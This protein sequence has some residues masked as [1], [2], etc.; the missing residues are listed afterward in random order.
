MCTSSF[1]TNLEHPLLSHL[2]SSTRAARLFVGS[3]IVIATTVP[4]LVQADDSAAVTA[5]P[6]GTPVFYET[7]TVVAR[8][9]AT[10]SGSVSVV[11]SSEIAASE[12]QS[13][14]DLLREVPGANVLSSG[15]AAGV[16]HASLR[17][18]DPNFTL[19]LL[20]GIPLN[21]TTEMQGGA[22]NLQ[23]L[24]LNLV[25]RVEVVRGPLCSFYGVSSLSGVV[26]LFTRRGG[27]GP[28][29]ALL[30]IEAGNAS[31]RHGYGAVSGP[32]GRGGYA[33]GASWTGEQH[34]VGQDRFRQFD[35]HAS[36]DIALAPATALALTGRYASGKTDDYP[37]SSG[38]PIY[39]SGELRHS[40]HDD[41][42][43]GARLDFGKDKAQQ[44]TFEISFARRSRNRVSPEVPPIVPAS[45]ED[46]TYSRLRWGWRMPV[47]MS[48][49]AALDAGLSGDAE[50]ADDTSLLHLAPFMGGDTP[51]SYHKWRASGGI[52][53]ALRQELG[54]VSI[55]GALRLDASTTDSLQVNP[56]VGLVWRLG[57]G[58]TR[59]RAN[60]GRASKLASFTALASPKALGGNPNLKPERAVGG[61][62]GIERTLR[63]LKLDAGATLF[64]QEYRDLIDFDFASFGYVNRA[65]V[66]SQGAELHLRWTPRSQL[67]ADASAT[68]IDAKDLDGSPL[69]QQPHWLGSARLTWQ[70][71]SRLSLRLD[72]RA[73]SRYYDTEYPAPERDFVAG[74]GVFGFAGS[75]RV[76]RAWT[77]RARLDNLANRAYETFIGFPGPRRSFW[78][79]V[80][81]ERP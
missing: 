48:T 12:A 32:W 80:G 74:N 60:V 62:I 37:D 71:S 56:H 59:L 6:A 40:T 17:G 1:L 44:R 73:V 51:G 78:V 53:S 38:G 24:S 29:R 64:R 63:S 70:P 52:F 33:A 61:E 25:D 79:G 8:P 20:D 50:W 76:E 75:W 42:A 19:V 10:A 66:R 46:V 54:A 41:V 31:S 28:V 18:G 34:R 81:W 39:G 35:G 16:S 15:G 2:A 47:A 9:L 58:G 30:G 77:L 69:L 68:W 67:T 27:P 49:H 11:D 13:A 5:A 23:E 7:T 21:D 3:A 4:G 65:R 22:V 36:T 72:C 14:A 45:E 43:L 26:Q 57:N 55:E